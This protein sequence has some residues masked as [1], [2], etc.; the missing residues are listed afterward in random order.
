MKQ[1]ENRSVRERAK[2]AGIKHWQIALS[3]GVSEQTFMRWLRVPLSQDREH[4]ILE[5][6]DA[7]SEEV[8]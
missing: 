8:N 1:N 2:E 5:A 4:Q 3:L 7:L 6:I